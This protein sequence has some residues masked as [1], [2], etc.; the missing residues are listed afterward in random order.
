MIARRVVTLGLCASTGCIETL[1]S[2]EI[3]E[4]R[5]FGDVRGAV[6]MPLTAPISDRDGNVYV[7]YG[8]PEVIEV[9]A[10]VGRAGG[11]W[12]GGCQVHEGTQRGA[13]GWVGHIQDRAWYWSGD[14]L[15]EVDGTT[16]SCKNLLDRDP[17]SAA[18]LAFVAVV[19]DVRET[20]SRNTMVAMI[21]SVTD[22]VPFEVVIDLDLGIYTDLTRFV[23]NNAV[24]VTVLGSGRDDDDDDG[25]G[26]VLVQYMI[27]DALRV[28]GRFL[29]SAARV[30]DVAAITEYPAAAEN[31]PPIAV[32]GF[33]QGEGQGWVA[34]VLENGDVL[35]FDRDGGRIRATDG[36]AAVGVHRFE[37]T[38]WI[39][40]EK[41]GR[42][43]IAALAPSGDIGAAQGWVSSERIARRLAAG[44]T[45]LDDRT[46]PI[47]TVRWSSARAAVGASAFLHAEN[48]HPYA[49]GVT[50]LLVAGPAYETAGQ[51][52]TTVAIAPVGIAYP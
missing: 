2:G 36:L 42:P 25:A 3:G 39:V 43:A 40:G 18:D 14:A 7:L 10:Y 47:D 49:D 17:V 26:F 16:G 29:D 27:G 20:P 33:L 46:A 35:V 41:N 9:T 45:V 13:Y 24:D 8:A 37:G 48:P 1:G 23:P 31:E 32:A 30:S 4:L 34:G 21:Q 22:S 11:G 38:T 6:P 5:T 51:S 52:F 44:V 12:T 19:P 15:V 50:L 28:E